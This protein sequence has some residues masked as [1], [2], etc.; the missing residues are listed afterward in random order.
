[1]ENMKK[2]N[3]SRWFLRR[4]MCA[5]L[6]FCTVF[7][8][9]AATPVQVR[10]NNFVEEYRDMIGQG[11]YIYYV[12]T[13]TTAKGD[14]A[15]I[16][17]MKVAT[18]EKSKVIEE[19]HGII[20]MCVSGP[21]LFYTTYSEDGMRWEIWHCNL[22]G[23]EAER[24][25][26]GCLCYADGADLYGIKYVGAKT[27]LFHVGLSAN[28]KRTAVK[29]VKEGTV[30]DYAC[31][32]DKTS[33]YYTY[34]GKT[35][36]IA[37]Y[38]LEKGKTKLKKLAT[39]KRAENDS[40]SALLVSDVKRINGELYYNYGSYEGSGHFWYGTIKKLTAD[41]KKKVVGK[42]VENDTIIA[43]TK[44]LYFYDSL[45]G[46]YY[47]YDLAAGKKT[48][49]AMEYKEGVNYIILGDKTY[50]ADTSNKKKITISRFNSGTAQETLT[51]DF[52]TI[53]FKQKANVSYSVSMRQVGIYNMVC[54]T[55]TDFTDQSY[56]WNGNVVSVDWYITDGAGTVLGSFR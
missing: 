15:V 17:R 38:A 22:D 11:G 33:Y 52:I 34:N 25:C 4:L 16:Y 10:A 48:K 21:N 32:V 55:G 20:N 41:G 19:T 43:G 6:V 40:N 12:K 2:Q 13:K 18:A 1:M 36:R 46:C 23:S 30:L 31:T 45:A 24:V 14:G 37:L 50:M 56:G 49:Y 51:K 42:N 7:A 53:P 54:V 39:E 27:R 35:E 28:G 26:D 5:A 44:E 8:A 9:F 3:R 47:K 29:T